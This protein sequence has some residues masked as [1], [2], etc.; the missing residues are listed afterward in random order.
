MGILVHKQIPAPSIFVEIPT[1]DGALS[2]ERRIKTFDEGNH[3]RL[4]SVRLRSITRHCV[5]KLHII[6]APPKYKHFATFGKRKPA[7]S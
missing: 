2:E 4:R 1:D 5:H 6:V 7:P 3:E